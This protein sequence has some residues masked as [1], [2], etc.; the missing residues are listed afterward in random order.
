MSAT[1]KHQV[2]SIPACK[3][4]AVIAPLVADDLVIA[5]PTPDGVTTTACADDVVPGTGINGVGPPG[6]GDLVIA[7]TGLDQVAAIGTD[8]VVAITACDGVG[9]TISTDG[10]VA[11]TGVNLVISPTGDNQVVTCA[12][13][14]HAVAAI[15]MNGVVTL[16]APQNVLAPAAGEC[17]VALTAVEHIAWAAG[18]RQHVVTAVAIERAA[19]PTARE[20]IVSGAAV[21]RGVVGVGGQGVVACQR[22]RCG[23]IDAELRTGRCS[24]CVRDNHLDADDAHIAR[25]RCAA[26]S[27]R[28]RIERQP[29]RQCAAIGPR[30]G[31][32]QRVVGVNI[33]KGVCRHRQGKRCI[34]I[35]LLS[36][37]RCCHDWRIIHIHHVERESLFGALRGGLNRRH[38]DTE[39]S[40]LTVAWCATE[41]PRHGVKN[42]PVR[43]CLPRACQPGVETKRCIGRHNKGICG[44]SE[45]QRVILQYLLGL[46]RSTAN[47][48]AALSRATRWGQCQHLLHR[49]R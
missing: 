26:E 37:N 45:R 12:G 4:I 34:R 39:H 5:Q 7:C 19:G 36:C 40:H 2:L 31:V 48:S 9:A 16:A 43:Q 42:Q 47:N 14:D 28:H 10:V 49:H 11:L 17:V 44:N 33:D 23:H 22:V 3:H 21:Q 35:R 15:G 18:S 6:G 38:L 32:D 29:G 46:D 30:G 1:I 8:D 24:G 13:A 20:G 27:L 25:T 41:G